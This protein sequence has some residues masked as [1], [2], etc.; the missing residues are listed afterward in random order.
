MTK[1]VLRDFK[2]NST[3]RGV[4]TVSTIL[5]SRIGKIGNLAGV[6]YIVQDIFQKSLGR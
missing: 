2:Q 4:S 6:P 1:I 5:S 3:I